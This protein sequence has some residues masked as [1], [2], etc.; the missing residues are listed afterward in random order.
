MIE[1]EQPPQNAQSGVS[2]YIVACDNQNSPIAHGV[3]DERPNGT[4]VNGIKLTKGR[5][6][7]NIMRVVTPAALLPLS[8]NGK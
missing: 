8:P 5:H 6:V 7:V 1:H 3:L 4:I 2:V